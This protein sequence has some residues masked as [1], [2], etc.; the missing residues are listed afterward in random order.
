METAKAKLSRRKKDEKSLHDLYCFEDAIWNQMESLGHNKEKVG[1]T[2]PGCFAWHE[3]RDRI[4]DLR[5]RLKK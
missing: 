5:Q 1:C 4:R 2:C 3:L